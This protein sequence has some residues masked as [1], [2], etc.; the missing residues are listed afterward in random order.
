MF[1]HWIVILVEVFLCALVI[2]AW[3]WLPDV[4]ITKH[5]ISMALSKGGV[6]HSKVQRRKS[7]DDALNA[8]V[9]RQRKRR[10]SEEALRI[11]G[12]IIFL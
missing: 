11:S 7:V 10:P 3:Q 4:E 1:Q 9:S 6:Y 12:T 5:K 8:A 2:F